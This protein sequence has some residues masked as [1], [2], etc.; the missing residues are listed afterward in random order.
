MTDLTVIDLNSRLLGLYLQGRQPVVHILI[1]FT[2]PMD[3][4]AYHLRQSH[5]NLELQ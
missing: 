2:R 4:G 5:H 3:R 1:L